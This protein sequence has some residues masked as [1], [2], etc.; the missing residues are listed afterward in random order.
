MIGGAFSTS[1]SHTTPTS[2]WIVQQLREALPMEPSAK[3]LILDHD[4]KYGTEM[5]AAIRGIDIAPIRIAIGCPWQNGV[6]ERWVESCRRDLLDHIIAV[7]EGHLKDSL[8]IT[9]ATITT[10][11]RISD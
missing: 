4:A 7:D 9:F 3:F 2:T 11:A 5:R 10:T 1:M 8:R 6:A